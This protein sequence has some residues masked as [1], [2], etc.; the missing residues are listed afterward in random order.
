MLVPKQEPYTN[1]GMTKLIGSKASNSKVDGKVYGKEKY[2]FCPECN[3]STNKPESLI[4]HYIRIH[5]RNKG[6]ACRF[7]TKVQGSKSQVNLHVLIIHDGIGS[8]NKP[9]KI[10]LDLESLKKRKA[11]YNK[12]YRT[13]LKAQT[14][15]NSLI[16]EQIARNPKTLI[17]D[18]SMKGKFYP[19]NTRK[20][21]HNDT[22]KEHNHK[23]TTARSKKGKELSN[24]GDK[25]LKPYLKR[26]NGIALT[27]SIAQYEKNVLINEKRDRNLKTLT[28]DASTKEDECCPQS[29]RKN[30]SIN[31]EEDTKG[32]KTRSNNG[33]QLL[34]KEYET[35]NDM[36]VH[37]ETSALEEETTFYSAKSTMKCLEDLINTDLMIDMV[38]EDDSSDFDGF[39]QFGNK[40]DE[41]CLM[42]CPVKSCIMVFPSR[43]DIIGHLETDH[44][45]I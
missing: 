23:G 34:D 45:L 2:L 22:Q 30:I 19:Q 21:I 4:V 8:Y 32:I 20:M 36:I 9:R 5:D 33:K 17:S 14:E 27:K 3:Y 28:I 39:F 40:F 12:K 25:T 41:S 38:L 13:K 10:G 15:N 26:Q 42:K 44:N 35:F 16:I 29:S 6:I 18:A 7:C 24:I 31:P 43:E 11:M 37:T 1:L